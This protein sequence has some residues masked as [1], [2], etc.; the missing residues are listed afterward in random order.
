VYSFQVVRVGRNRTAWGIAPVTFAALA[1]VAVG[2][3]GPLDS[4]TVPPPR[5][6]H[7]AGADVRRDAPADRRADV[8][9]GNLDRSDTAG[10]TFDGRRVDG[11]MAD[12]DAGVD[13]PSP[14]DAGWPVLVDCIS[15]RPPSPS[16]DPMSVTP[17]LTVGCGPLSRVVVQ[18]VDL[19]HQGM[20]FDAQ[21]EPPV[22]GFDLARNPYLCGAQTSAP[23]YIIAS[24]TAGL[25]PSTSLQTFLRVTVQGPGQTQLPLRAI[26]L[27]ISVAATD[28]TLVDDVVDFGTVVQGG[29][30]VRDLTVINNLASAPIA[31]LYS[32]TLGDPGPFSL[33]SRGLDSTGAPLEPGNTGA[34]LTASFNPTSAGSYQATFLVS[35]FVPGTP[36]DPGCGTIARLTMR[37]Q[38]VPRSPPP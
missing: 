4:P 26:P 35:P 8:A 6:I 12:V 29:Y 5:V 3:S 25:T 13:V 32:S 10:D 16:Y 34:L 27:Y 2:C 11:G 15:G 20:F 28:F 23:I 21:L 33:F 24:G 14:A 1:S 7:D 22:P 37:G 17:V 38:V 18:L 9:D 19:A 30:S 31:Y 36:I